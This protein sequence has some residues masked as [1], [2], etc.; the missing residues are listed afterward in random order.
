MM[1]GDGDAQEQRRG[2]G[3]QNIQERGFGAKSL[4]RWMGMGLERP[5][6]ADHL[7]AI[8][9]RHLHDFYRAI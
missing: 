9:F 3:L 2:T 7:P 8:K 5:L 1:D 6:L 4:K